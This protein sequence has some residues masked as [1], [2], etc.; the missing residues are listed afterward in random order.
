MFI[1]IGNTGICYL[2]L[3]YAPEFEEVESI[4]APLVLCFVLSYMLARVFM[5]VYGT[6]SITILQCLY[7]DVDIAGQEGKDK[8]DNPHRP[9]EMDPIVAM[10]K[11]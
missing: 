1:S 11:V 9:P 10:L 2:I 4:I 6:T 3:A 7:V 8:L 5:D